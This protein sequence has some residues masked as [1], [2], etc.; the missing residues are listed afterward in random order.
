MCWKWEFTDYIMGLYVYIKKYTHSFLYPEFLTAA[1]TY[2]PQLLPL[3]T[4][5]EILYGQANSHYMLH[6]RL[7]VPYQK[8]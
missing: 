1:D 7:L 5:I 3:R 4:F 2:V 6:K 8:S